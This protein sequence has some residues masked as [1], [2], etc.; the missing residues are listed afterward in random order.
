MLNI[1]WWVLA[2]E[3]LCFVKFEKFVL[4]CIWL[5]ICVTM[6]LVKNGGKLLKS[7]LISV[8]II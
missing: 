1:E 8:T 6:Y 2:L 5:K 4:T 3:L 7:C